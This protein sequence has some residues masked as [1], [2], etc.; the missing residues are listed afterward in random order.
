MIVPQISFYVAD[1]DVGVAAI[2]SLNLT[3]QE[4]EL[5]LPVLVLCGDTS[6][7]PGVSLLL[8]SVLLSQT[9]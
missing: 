9:E 6:L 8:A 2:E 5:F 3:E 7:V 4:S 1:W